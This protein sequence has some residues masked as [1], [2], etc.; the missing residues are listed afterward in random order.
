LVEVEDAESLAQK[1]LHREAYR[2]SPKLLD[3]AGTL[4]IDTLFE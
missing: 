1:L 4:R 3:T 2:L